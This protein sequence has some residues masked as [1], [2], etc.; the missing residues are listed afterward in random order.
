MLF[1]HGLELELL[2]FGSE[3]SCRKACRLPA[4]GV[5]DF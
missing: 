4:P 3:K 2:E 1:E 5:K